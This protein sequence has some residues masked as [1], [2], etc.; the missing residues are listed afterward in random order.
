[1]QLKV[2]GINDCAELLVVSLSDQREAHIF[3]RR[4]LPEM[5]LASVS[6]AIQN[7]WLAARAEG[8][9]MGW[10]SMFDPAKLSALL[11]LPDDAK[12]IAILCLG[13][14]DDFYSAPMLE[15]ENW[16][17]GVQ[18]N[19]VLYENQW[20]QK[21]ESAASSSCCWHWLSTGCSA[22]RNAGTRW[23]V[24]A[25]WY[26]PSNSAGTALIFRPAGRLF[27]EA[28]LGCYLFCP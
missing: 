21:A 14:V 26:K 3:G 16:R 25:S 12:P 7:M 18:L 8:L 24:S 5:D 23:L 9:G 11:S 10:V 22:S 4:T 17:Q 2:E 1:M 6:C 20:G 19:D 27:V 15:Q 13:H 28:W